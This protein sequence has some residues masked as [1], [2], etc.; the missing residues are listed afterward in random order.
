MT[1]L[2]DTTSPAGVIWN[3][4]YLN[5]YNETFHSYLVVGTANFS[6]CVEAVEEFVVVKV[7]LQIEGPMGVRKGEYGNDMGRGRRNIQR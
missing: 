7:K 4:C 2:K 1:P 6:A 3:P 5:G